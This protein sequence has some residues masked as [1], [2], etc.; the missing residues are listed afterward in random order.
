MTVIETERL[1]MRPWARDDIDVYAEMFANDE[2]M[3]FSLTRRGM[4]RKE[5]EESLERHVSHFEKHGYGYW[6]VTPKELGRIAGYT[7]LQMPYWFPD[8]LPAVEVGYRYHPDHWGNGYATEAARASLDYGFHVV[9]LDEIIAIYEPE[10]VRSG[11]VMERLGMRHIR[12]VRDP[13]DSVPLR[14]YTITRG[15]WPAQP[16]AMRIKPPS[17]PMYA[18]PSGPSE[19]GA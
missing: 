2:I 8:L 14:I 17:E 19:T 4:T 3:R 18:E 10:N 9:G 5:A 7:G 6:A 13:T 1:I 16:S 11:M 15:E 12:D